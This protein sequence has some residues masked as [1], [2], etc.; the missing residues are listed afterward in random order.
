M[1]R[2][3]LAPAWTA[4]E[5]DVGTLR[6]GSIE[7]K[8]WEHTM[9]RSPKDVPTSIASG[10]KSTEPTE[11]PTSDPQRDGTDPLSSRETAEEVAADDQT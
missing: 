2:I 4:D 1:I 8:I 9:A 7:Q 3:Q 5:G 6:C 10:S 11:R